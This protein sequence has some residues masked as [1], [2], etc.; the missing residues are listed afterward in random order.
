[1]RDAPAAALPATAASLALAPAP[2]PLWA[3]PPDALA[4]IAAHLSVAE[5]LRL[6]AT[7]SAW[8]EACQLDAIW[9]PTFRSRWPVRS[10]M[11]A[12]MRRWAHGDA[13]RACAR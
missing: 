12:C 7:C 11:L 3:L 8:R 6:R 10:A 9:A 1:M 4:L 5:L 2:A 13:C